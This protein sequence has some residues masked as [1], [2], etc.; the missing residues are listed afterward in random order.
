MN[1]IPLKDSAIVGTTAVIS[2]L[3]SFGLLQGAATR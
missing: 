2:S 1:R 3:V